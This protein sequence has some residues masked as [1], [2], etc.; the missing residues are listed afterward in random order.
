MTSVTENFNFDPTAD[1][2]RVTAQIKDSISGEV[3]DTL[4]IT[5]TPPEIPPSG[6]IP[7]LEDGGVDPSFWTPFTLAGLAGTY[8]ASPPFDYPVVGRFV[9]PPY[10]AHDDEDHKYISIVAPP[11]Q[12]VINDSGTLRYNKIDRIEFYLNGNSS[13]VIVTEPESVTRG[14]D[15][16]TV[17]HPFDLTT[18]DTMKKTN[19]VR[20]IIYY[21]KGEPRILQ[22]MAEPNIEPFRDGGVNDP[23]P[24][25]QDLKA[26]T[27]STDFSWNSRGCFIGKYEDYYVGPSGNDTTNDGRSPATAVLT[28]VVAYD[29][30]YANGHTNIRVNNSHVCTIGA[31]LGPNPDL[32]GPA[33]AY[34]GYDLT[35]FFKEGRG[36]DY[37]GTSGT[38]VGGNVRDFVHRETL[39]AIVRGGE[40]WVNNLN[41]TI[42]FAHGALFKN[43]N[44]IL[45]ASVGTTNKGYTYF[46][47]NKNKGDQYRRWTDYCAVMFDGCTIGPKAK[48]DSKG[49]DFGSIEDH[50]YRDTVGGYS[51]SLADLGSYY[52]ANN[53]AYNCTINYGVG[54]SG[55]EMVD[56]DIVCSPTQNDIAN[57][58]MIVNTNIYDVNKHFYPWGSLGSPDGAGE[59]I[60]FGVPISRGRADNLIL[61]DAIS[62]GDTPSVTQ[63]SIAERE[64][65]DN[66]PEHF[67]PSHLPY[68]KGFWPDYT[69]A[70]IAGVQPLDG[71]PATGNQT[72]I[73]MFRIGKSASEPGGVG[74]ESNWYYDTTVDPNSPWY[75][76]KF[77]D[78]PRDPHFDLQQF[79]EVRKNVIVHRMKTESVRAGFQGIFTTDEAHI[80]SG[81]FW[82]ITWNIPGNQGVSAM[83]IGSTDEKNNSNPLVNPTTL[84]E[85]YPFYGNEDIP[86]GQFIHYGPD[87]FEFHTD[88][89]IFIPR[90]IFTNS[91]GNC[92]KDVWIYD[93]NLGGNWDS[94]RGWDNGLGD[95]E[96][97]EILRNRDDI[98]PT[99]ST[100]T[101]CQNSNY[102]GCLPP[103]VP[104]DWPNYAHEGILYTQV[105]L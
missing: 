75:G 9:T 104:A 29:K 69:M 46:L 50:S 101:N 17:E 70:Q 79:N 25:V 38:P 92:A 40:M 52:T 54:N 99:P 51:L 93:K 11:Y 15:C 97:N 71:Q 100:L 72:N 43:C 83:C 37:N 87:I 5:K 57:Y 68:D 55:K 81:A 36:L 74:N 73:N 96:V 103:E 21:E 48:L 6:S 23:P 30:A 62:Y 102:G 64:P 78:K 28:P 58:G 13:R 95:G 8:D 90:E 26:I 63:R 10:F 19:E 18:S 88:D 35:R 31:E 4:T 61:H 27:M 34:D 98:S 20:A 60:E 41:A 89:Q 7:L 3:I 77:S 56:C 39:P 45:N 14:Y 105:K 16:Y 44:M 84:P 94:I 1:L 42:T 59:S 65:Y 80:E 32:T 76:K 47:R 66:N 86:T 82:D 85:D 22:G 53:A 24:G 12:G 49:G 2:V 91:F 67:D 33:A